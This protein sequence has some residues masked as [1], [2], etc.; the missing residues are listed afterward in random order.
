MDPGGR[1]NLNPAERSTGRGSA[2]NDWWCAHGCSAA[3]VSRLQGYLTIG[4]RAA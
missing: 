3:V 2:M 4:A 1:V